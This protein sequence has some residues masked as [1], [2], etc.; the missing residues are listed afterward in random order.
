MTTFG[1]QDFL[2][3][4][5]VGFWDGEIPVESAEGGAGT[6]PVSINGRPYVIDLKKYQRRTLAQFRQ[7]SD[8]SRE[9]GEQSLSIEGVWKRTGSSSYLGAGQ[10]FYD[11]DDSE[12]RQFYR[13]RGIDPWTPRQ[14]CLLRDTTRVRTTV[15]SDLHVAKVNGHIVFVDGATVL[16]SSDPRD[17]AWTD[18]AIG[19]SGS[20]I[21]SITDDGRTLYAACGPDG[22]RTVI[23][24][25]PGGA[26]LVNGATFPAT[27]IVFANGWLVGA[28]AHELK[29]VAAGG[30]VTDLFEHRV[31]SFE[32]VAGTGSPRAIYL[33]GNSGE[34]GE[35]YR[36]AVD[37]T[38]AQLAT[39]VFAGDV[40]IGETIHTLAYYSGIVLIGT[41]RG[42]RVASVLSDGGLEV[43][44][45]IEDPSG[46][47]CA[48]F[49]T[50]GQFAWF[51]M[52][53]PFDSNRR[54]L[55]RADLSRFTEAN[56]PAWAADLAS[57]A[58][59]GRTVGVATWAEGAEEYRLFA[60]AGSGLWAETDE[61]VVDGVLDLGFLAQNSPESKTLQTMSVA[62][63]F[64][65]G[66]ITMTVTNES[67]TAV[68]AVQE[69]Q[70]TLR[71]SE[72]ERSVAG[73]R[74][75]VSL[76]LARDVD[77]PTEGPCLR[78]WTIRVVPAP[79]TVEEIV[80]PLL[81]GD[82]VDD[83]GARV[84]AYDPFVEFYRL[85]QLEAG[86]TV[87]NYREGQATYRVTIR[88]IAMPEGAHKWAGRRRFFDTTLFVR[89][90]T[91]DGIPPKI[92]GVP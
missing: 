4:F 26:V 39:P 14:V 36:T 72:F 69:N 15:L 58:T 71:S 59:A 43:G 46:Q 85:K 16:A 9:P 56:V 40:P 44:P 75:D 13:S 8:T 54:G 32:W 34:R 11:D 27:L 19:G 47:G 60:V 89:M 31:E 53:N 86:K 62:H 68:S 21:T 87:I 22:I 90:L 17:G 50:R 63:D 65:V 52:V 23:P 91:L 18:Q 73:E 5:D 61:L 2:H 42:V 88:E 78:R 24:G 67:G 35:I 55:G 25:T 6:A 3:G 1:V 80:A 49:E 30:V 79:A 29:V 28:A 83:T 74:L 57:T 20:T 12:R 37:D 76:T 82:I 48:C 51:G 33:A 92:E 38:G 7:Q 41:S 84:Y 45:V 70:G 77:D 66:S 10:E 64:L 81:M